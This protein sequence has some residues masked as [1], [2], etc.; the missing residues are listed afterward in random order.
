MLIISKV[1]SLADV[2]LADVSL[3]VV[4]LAVISLA[5]VGSFNLREAGRACFLTLRPLQSS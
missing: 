2:S 5:V 1:V 4:S 3:A